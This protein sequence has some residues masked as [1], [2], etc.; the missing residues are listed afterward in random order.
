MKPKWK[1]SNAYKIGLKRNF[2]KPG[3]HGSPKRANEP[4]FDPFSPFLGQNGS[5]NGQKKF[6]PI[7]LSRMTEKD[8]QKT[9]F[10]HFSKISIFDPFWD[11]KGPKMDKKNF[12]DFFCPELTEK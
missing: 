2:G 1:N 11:K 7:Y 4:L 10:K 5:K 12:F 3:P 9:I 8:I 6:F